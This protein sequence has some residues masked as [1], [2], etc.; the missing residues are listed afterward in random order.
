MTM[1]LPNRRHRTRPTRTCEDI[2]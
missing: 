2:V 1:L